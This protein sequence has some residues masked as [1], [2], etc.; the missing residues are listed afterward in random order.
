MANAILSGQERAKTRATLVTKLWQFQAAY[1]CIE[2][3]ERQNAMPT[4]EWSAPMGALICANEALKRECVFLLD[5]ATDTS[6]ITYRL[7]AIAAVYECVKA[8][9]SFDS[10]GSDTA[11]SDA[12]VLLNPEFDAAIAALDEVL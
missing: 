8:K 3:L 4:T 1:S 11:V 2:A 7:W 12:L 10:G 9:V 6:S 5:S